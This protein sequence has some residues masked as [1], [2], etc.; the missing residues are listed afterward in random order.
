MML[1]DT[2]EQL[3]IYKNCIG[4]HQHQDMMVHL[5]KAESA[6]ADLKKWASI[7]EKAMPTKLFQIF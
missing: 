2:S 4:L 5:Q 3:R 1:H 7:C 6:S